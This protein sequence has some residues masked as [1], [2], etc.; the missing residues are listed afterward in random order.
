MIGQHIGHPYLGSRRV[1][2]QG[3]A[4]PAANQQQHAQWVN[5]DEEPH[6]VVAKPGSHGYFCS[7]HTHMVGTIIVRQSA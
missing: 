6:I 3:D 1:P 2:L 7:I 4:E 5:R